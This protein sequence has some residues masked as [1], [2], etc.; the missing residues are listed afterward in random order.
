MTSTPT[1]AML[2]AAVGRP[3]HI[4]YGGRAVFQNADDAAEAF[5]RAARRAHAGAPAYTLGGSSAS[6]AEIVAA[7]EA[8]APQ[9]RGKITF[10]PIQLP[11][12]E[13]VDSAALDA[14]L[15]VMHWTPLAQGVRR[16]IEHFQAAIAAGRMDVERAI[17]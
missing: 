11:N 13:D 2:A 4:S 7:I 15:G 5:I 17:A 8:A 3:Y 1:K 9:M 16:T 6:M 14:A 12:P 10:E